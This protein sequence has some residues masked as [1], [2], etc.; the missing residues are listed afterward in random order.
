MSTFIAQSVLSESSQ[1]HACRSLFQIP[2]APLSYRLQAKVKVN[3]PGDKYEQEADRVAE[4]VMRMPEP[5]VQRQCSCGKGSASCECEECK[6]K[7]VPASGFLQREATSAMGGFTAPPC[8]NEVLSSPG[9]PLPESTRTFMESRFGHDFSHVRVHTGVRAAESAAAVQAK[10]Y[11]ASNHVVFGAGQD[12]FE[13]HDGRSLLAHELT[14]V[15]QQRRETTPQV[16]RMRLPVP[17][18]PPLCGKTLTHIHIEPPRARPLEPCQP[19]SVMVTRMNIVGRDTTRGTS[20]SGSMVFN[21]H[22]GYYVDPATGRYCGIVDDSK[23]CVAGRCMV[24]GCFPTLKEVL[25][26]LLNALQTL[27]IAA[28]LV[29]LAALAALLLGPLLAFA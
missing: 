24:L 3:Q 6:K 25:D 12:Q 11:T 2:D 16:R 7:K 13:T 15:I 21:L 1:R 23:G 4:Q 22:V 26:A 18:S 20:P 28:G 5:S 19:A 14:H 9:S 17:G 27:L 29:A 10:A 8:V